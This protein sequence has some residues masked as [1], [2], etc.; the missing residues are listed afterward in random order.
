MSEKLITP[1]AVADI[2]GFHPRTIAEMGKRGDIPGAVIIGRHVRF[3]AQ[4]VN[5]FLGR[6]GHLPNEAETGAVKSMVQMK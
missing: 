5:D 3:D 4:S 2:T 6:R 1:R